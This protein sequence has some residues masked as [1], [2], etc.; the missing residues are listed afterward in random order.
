[1]DGS[2]FSA[3][4]MQSITPHI[5]PLQQTLENTT[6]L[7]ATPVVSPTL[8]LLQVKTVVASHVF[9]DPPGLGHRFSSFGQYLQQRVEYHN[10]NVSQRSAPMEY[11]PAH[12]A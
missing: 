9:F 8:Y 5:A 2:S 12:D 11:V 7:V 6:H 1:M 10:D 4:H 3:L